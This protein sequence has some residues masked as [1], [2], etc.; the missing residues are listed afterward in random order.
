MQM[1]DVHE[2][3]EMLRVSLSP[4]GNTETQILLVTKRKMNQFAEQI[5]TIHLNRHKVWIS[6]DIV[7]MKFPEYVLPVFT[8]T[9]PQ[10]YI[11]IMA[12]VMKEFLPKMGI[13]RNVPLDLLYVPKEV[14]G[15]DFKKPLY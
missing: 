10:S 12:P 15:F 9:R 3:K 13:N 11:T 8:I 2:A 4:D 14:Q 6:L 1:L 7:A 5:G